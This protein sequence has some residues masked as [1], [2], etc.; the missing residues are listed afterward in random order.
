MAGRA[1]EAE[2]DGPA[3][4]K[5]DLCRLLNQVLHLLAGFEFDHA[6]RG[7][8]HIVFGPI[9]VS[10]DSG[11][12]HGDVENPEIPELDVVALCKPFAYIV[13]RFLND[14]EHLLLGQAC[15]VRYADHKVPLCHVVNLPPIY[16]P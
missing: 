7:N 14:A 4:A 15:F 2:P 12:S 1:L 3:G 9:R 11:F 8:R 5:S 10:A 13:E 6:S 16:A